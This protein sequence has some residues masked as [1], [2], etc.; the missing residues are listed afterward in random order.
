MIRAIPRKDRK[1]LTA[2]R[3]AQLVERRTAVREVEGSGFCCPSSVKFALAIRSVTWLFV[4]LLQD[5]SVNYHCRNF[6]NV[7]YLV[8]VCSNITVNGRLT[9]RIVT[10]IPVFRLNIEVNTCFESSNCQLIIAMTREVSQ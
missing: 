4:S 2:A 7:L 8:Q 6:S 9:V 3:L 5:E 10:N 1:E